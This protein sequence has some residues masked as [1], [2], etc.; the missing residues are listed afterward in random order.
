MMYRNRELDIL[1]G[2]GIL[3]MIFDHVHFGEHVH[4]YIQSFHMP[5]FFIISG[6]LWK[7]RSLTQTIARRTKTLCVPYCVFSV[8]AFLLGAVG[9]SLGTFDPIKTVRAICL[10]PTD[11]N[12]M[13]VLTALW[14]LPCMFIT[15]VIYASLG[16]I[17]LL[18]KIACI[19]IIS[20][21]GAI[22][23]Y[24]SDQMLPFCLEAVAVALPFMLFGEIIKTYK[25]DE[26]LFSIR[27][28]FVF[29]LAVEFIL[30][31]INGCVDMRSARFHFLPLYYINSITG[32]L[33]FW[34]LV[35]WM[36]DLRFVPVVKALKLLEY[37]G[38]ISIMF[39]CIHQLPIQLF[40]LLQLRIAS[41]NI[42]IKL[43]IKI[44]SFM[45]AI[46]VCLSVAKA[47]QRRND[48][49]RIFGLS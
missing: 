24:S 1:K 42:M 14:F 30:A 22:W 4:T 25:I 47:A 28:I 8:L 49:K 43:G 9:L 29:L 31:F 10:F 5:L 12:N 44:L 16:S 32:T 36:Q 20:A 7:Q 45:I 38:S 37:I 35:K 18:W 46:I 26:K 27:F 6:Y 3:L 2:V 15:S 23:S 21:S 40:I 48:I 13:P 41:N 33:G 17:K 19:A 39:L 11:M 34:G